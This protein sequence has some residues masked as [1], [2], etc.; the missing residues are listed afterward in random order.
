MYGTQG[1]FQDF[2]QGVA[3]TSSGGSENLLEGGEK[4]A[5]YPLPLS[6]FCFPTQHH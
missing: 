4:I 2:F 5:R 3:E 1:R 6:I